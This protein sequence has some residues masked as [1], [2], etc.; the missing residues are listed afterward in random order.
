MEANRVHLLKQDMNKIH[1]SFDFTKIEKTEYTSQVLQ[2][3]DICI[4][5]QR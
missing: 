5:P 4:Q 2:D 1:I 3:F